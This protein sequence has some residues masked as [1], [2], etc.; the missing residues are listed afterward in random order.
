MCVE[1]I[2]IF[3]SIFSYCRICESLNFT[4]EIEKIVQLVPSSLTDWLMYAITADD[5]A[6]VMGHSVFGSRIIQILFNFYVNASHD[7]KNIR[8]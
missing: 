7:K 5:R 4:D 6:R 1:L 2:C 8:A 3:F